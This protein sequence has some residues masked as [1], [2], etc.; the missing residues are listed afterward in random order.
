MKYAKI[1]KFIPIVTNNVNNNVNVIII[2]VHTQ[3]LPV[4]FL[5]LCSVL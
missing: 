4:F 1:P 5:F 2:I 3:L